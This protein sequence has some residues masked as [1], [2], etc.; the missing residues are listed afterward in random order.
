MNAHDQDGVAVLA[1]ELTNMS[2]AELRKLAAILDALPEV[3]TLQDRIAGE[4]ELNLGWIRNA[5][6]KGDAVKLKEELV[7]LAME[8]ASDDAGE[9]KKQAAAKTAEEVRQ[10]FSKGNAAVLNLVAK[11]ESQYEKSAAIVALPETEFSQ[12][13][14]AFVAEVE[15]MDAITRIMLANRP[16]FLQFDRLRERDRQASM[17]MRMLK[18][19]IDIVRNGP[20]AVE[21]HV[22][23]VSRKPFVYAQLGPERFELSS[24]LL[25]DG[26]PFSL[27]FGPPKK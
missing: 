6:D 10:A 4:K 20:D 16:T 11:A 3:P 25:V 5:L 21:N 12:A 13:Y 15:S 7:A 17:R 22:D 23:T 14:A 1:R 19:A 18:A 8:S 24:A 27:S 2:P 26:K 9:E